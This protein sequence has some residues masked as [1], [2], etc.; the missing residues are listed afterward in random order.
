MPG[1]LPV[2]VL[3]KAKRELT[4]RVNI[5]IK[6]KTKSIMRIKKQRP[7]ET[8]GTSWSYLTSKLNLN[9]K[10]SYCMPSASA[11]KKKKRYIRLS[12]SIFSMFILDLYILN[13]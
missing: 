5:L 3:R 6:E 13:K 9:L 11:K 12:I 8:V 7:L 2:D 4:A 10:C 1:K